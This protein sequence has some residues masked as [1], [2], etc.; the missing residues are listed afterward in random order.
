MDDTA[1][2]LYN[3]YRIYVPA[4]YEGDIHDYGLCEFF[5][6]DLTHDPFAKNAFQAYID[7]WKK[8]QP[9]GTFFP[10][11]QPHFRVERKFPSAKHKNCQYFVLDACHDR[12]AIPSLRRY[13]W[14][15]LESYPMLANDLIQLINRHEGKYDEHCNP[16][17]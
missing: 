11:V 6:L 10:L 2:G 3:K 16:T 15:C 9:H 14:L 17:N 8:D 4:T 13:K 12:Y 1:L 7:S 5:V